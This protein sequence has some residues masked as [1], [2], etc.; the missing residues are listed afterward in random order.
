MVKAADGRETVE[1]TSAAALRRWLAKNCHQEHSVWL[2]TFKKNAGERYVSNAE[3]LDELVAFGWID[4]IRQKVD[5]ERTMQ[6]ISPR[7]TKPW[8]KSYKDR[9]ARLIA[10]GLMSPAGQAAIDEAKSSGAW[11]QMNEVDAFV[12]PDDL[13]DSLVRNAPALE[14]FLAFPPSTRR[15]ILRW[16]ALARKPETRE[17]R[18]ARIT[19]DASTGVR[20]P[21]NG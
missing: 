16:I 5:D 9:A 13:H 3:V 14:N 15:N 6:L 19:E 20:T 11:D 8:A 18:I 7:R 12:M 10:E 17:R 1:V 21:V 2:I 4:G